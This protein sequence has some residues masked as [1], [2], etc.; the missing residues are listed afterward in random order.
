VATPSSASPA[1]QGRGVNWKDKQAI[2]THMLRQRNSMALAEIESASRSVQS[3]ATSCKEFQSARIVGGYVAIGSEIRT[4]LILDTSIKLQKKL[5]LPRI[6]EGDIEFCQ[7]LSSDIKDLEPGPYGTREPNS[8]PISEE[9]DFLAVPGVAFDTRGYRIGYGKGYYDKFLKS[10]RP[11]FCA[12]LA[13]EFQ[14]I[15]RIPTMA[16]DAKLDAII[17]EKG[18]RYL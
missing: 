8:P 10:T 12:G 15:E 7:V 3:H 13:F 5:A 18:I 4:G 14:V 2:R 1:D 9:I 17:T 11:K 6:R 16:H